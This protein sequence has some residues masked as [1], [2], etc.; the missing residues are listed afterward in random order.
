[1]IERIGASSECPHRPEAQDVALS[2]PKHGFESRWGRQLGWQFDHS[3][4]QL[5][6]RNGRLK[7]VAAAARFADRRELD[8]PDER[9]TTS[10]QGRRKGAEAPASQLLKAKPR[11]SALRI[12]ALSAANPHR[13]TRPYDN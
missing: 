13:A 4:Q 8:R 9:Q 2:R 11:A 5:V 7:G 12:P 10:L 3:R 6:E 1:M